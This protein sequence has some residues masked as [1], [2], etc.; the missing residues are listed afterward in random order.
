MD[1]HQIVAQAAQQKASDI[2]V[3]PGLRLTFRILGELRPA[4]DAV[5]PSLAAGLAREAVGDDGWDEYLG[6]GS[7]DLARTISGVRCRI[8]ALQSM[9]G[10]GLAI[11]LLPSLQPDLESLNLHPDLRQLAQ[12]EHGLILISGPTGCGKSSTQAALLQEINLHQAR[13]IV[14][15]EQPIEYALR[16]ALSFIRQREV[17]RD[18]PSFE[19]ALLDALREDPD[20]IMLG[21]L[22]EPA[23]M[24]LALNAAET[25]HLV[26]ATVHSANVN[27]ALQRLVLAFPAEIQ[28]SIAA[29]LADCMAAVICQ[30]LRYRP[31]FDLRIPE[32][33]ILIATSSVRNNIRQAEWFKLGRPMET[34]ASDGMWTWDRYR[35][36]VEGRR[37]WHRPPPPAAVAEAELEPDRQ[38][39][40]RPPVRGARTTAAARARPEVAPE[41]TAPAEGVLE[42]VPPEAELA[43]ILSELEQAGRRGKK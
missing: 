40:P 19:Q 9:R 17:G 22:R 25:G 1:L 26:L 8:N 28:A 15:I 39:V 41:A 43:D 16:P 7:F 42:I 21:E 20:V 27:E 29:Q 2:H 13:H 34:G 33:E 14:T 23:C 11:R 12:R 32:C 3:E 6:R 35:A 18:T 30:R 38:S 37:D 24:R 5:T 10:H 36:W 31:E 4:G